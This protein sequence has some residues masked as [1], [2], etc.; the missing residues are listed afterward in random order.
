M[1]NYVEKIGMCGVNPCSP[2]SIYQWDGLTWQELISNVF[3]GV[4][5]CVSVVNNYTDLVSNTIEWIKTDGLKIYVENKIDGL[6]EDGTIS[7][8]INGEIFS[9][10]NDDISHI[11]ENV[12][13]NKEF[14]KEQIK[15]VE[16]KIIDLGKKID[17]KILKLSDELKNNL[18]EHKEAINIKI[19]DLGSE[20]NNGLSEIKK[21]LAIQ[22]GVLVYLNEYSEIAKAGTDEEDWS[23]AFDYVFKN[24]VNETVASIIW[25]GRLKIKSTI[26]LPKHVNISG[27]GLPWSGLIPLNNFKGDYVIEDNNEPT[28]NSIKNIYFDF[29]ENKTVKGLKVLNPYDYNE[30]KFLVADGIGDTFISIGGTQIS[31]STRIEDCV[32]YRE[33]RGSGA[34]MELRNCQEFYLVNNKLLF[35][36]QADKECLWCDGVTN[37][38]FI[39]NSFA[40]TNEVAV[41]M[42][43]NHYPKRLNGNVFTDNLFEGIGAGGCITIL[44]SS[45]PDLEGSYNSIHDNSYFSSTAIIN[46]GSIANTFISDPVK[47]NHLGGDR[48]TYLFNRYNET[49]KTPYGSV[50]EWC[51]GAYKMTKSWFKIIPTQEGEPSY[52]YMT[53]K[54]G[55]ERMITISSDGQLEIV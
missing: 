18:E 12:N 15:Q 52:L 43:A 42:L 7:E 21:A 11:K 1:K 13:S 51:D 28:H 54:S 24:V 8:I 55:K 35:K 53:D 14:T 33:N 49:S 6:I 22:K 10:I 25:N 19:E 34:I 4:N 17:D 46:L 45:N 48:R 30:Y 37:S 3:K 40:F 27:I 20:F 9:Q 2:M 31:Q 36:T 16:N 29:A 38:S 26:H 39:H 44:G 41:K 47:I 23:L 50:E 5:D 32:A